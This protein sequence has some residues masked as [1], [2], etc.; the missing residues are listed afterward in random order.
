[1]LNVYELLCG[2]GDGEVASA[3]ILL[4]YK[5]YM[6]FISNNNKTKEI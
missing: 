6:Y 4:C 2:G 3:Y 5:R 1:M